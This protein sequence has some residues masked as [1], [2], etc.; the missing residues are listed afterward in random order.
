MGNE[1]GSIPRLGISALAATTP[2]IERDHLLQ[3][4]TL[5]LQ[6]IQTKISE[7]SDRTISRELLLDCLSKITVSKLL[8]SFIT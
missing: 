5:I 3:L 6:A 1:L 4:K 8:L 2:A 7:E